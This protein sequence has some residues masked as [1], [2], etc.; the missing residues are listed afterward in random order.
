MGVAPKILVLCWL[1]AGWAGSE[2]PARWAV[3]D[4]GVR[5]R[6]VL[7]FLCGAL[8]TAHWERPSQ[9]SPL[10]A[11]RFDLFFNC[12][13]LEITHRTGWGEI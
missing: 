9:L 12:T 1:A 8:W 5:G 10:A 2:M 7:W 3:G 6:G 13:E 4:F 11:L